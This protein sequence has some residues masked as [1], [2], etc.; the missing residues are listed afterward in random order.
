MNRAQL[1]FLKMEEENLKVIDLVVFTQHG[2]SWDLKGIPCFAVLDKNLF[3][4]LKLFLMII[5]LL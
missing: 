3:F 4:I 1:C 5:E 2:N